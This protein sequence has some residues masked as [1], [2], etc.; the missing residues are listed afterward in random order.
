MENTL[1]YCTWFSGGLRIVD[2]ADPARPNEVGYYIP[3]PISG[4]AAPMSNDVDT[5][6]RGLIYLLDRFAGF[7]I[8]EFN[9][10]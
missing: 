5:D 4:N 8:L 9:R 10:G 6:G 3:E 1:V 2:I 7:D